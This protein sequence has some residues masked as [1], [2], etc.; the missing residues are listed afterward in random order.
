MINI[1]GQATRQRYL[2][3]DRLEAF[4]DG[5]FAIGATLLALEVT[6]P[7]VHEAAAGEARLC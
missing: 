5:V 7:V 4:V 1:Q 3:L 6:V 2:A